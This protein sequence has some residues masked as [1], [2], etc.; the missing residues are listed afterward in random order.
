MPATGVVAYMRKET[1]VIGAVA[2]SRILPPKE[3]TEAMIT[4]SLRAP[5]ALLKELNDIADAEGRSRND[6]M[7][8]FWTWAIQE[9][10]AEQGRKVKK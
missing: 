5:R 9:Y 6:V 1:P 7:L 8:H 10:R 4:T 2:V 3:K